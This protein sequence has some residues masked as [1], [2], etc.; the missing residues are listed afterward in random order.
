MSTSDSS[1]TA[2]ITG[3][4]RGLGAAIAAEL[5]A[6]GMNTAVNYLNRGEFKPY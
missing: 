3:A 6:M 1:R 2:L 4:S 5:A